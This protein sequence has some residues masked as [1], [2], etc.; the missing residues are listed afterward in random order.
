MRCK[1]LHNVDSE[2]EGI[3]FIN[4]YI[5]MYY[6]RGVKSK[7]NGPEWLF[8]KDYIVKIRIK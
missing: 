5:V 1:D 8:V 6:K 7:W 2:H 4:I 3:V